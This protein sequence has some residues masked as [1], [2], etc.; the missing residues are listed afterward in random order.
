MFLKHRSNKKELLDEENI[1]KKDLYENLKELNTINYFLG[2]Y[3]VS[4]RGFRK[5]IKQNRTVKTIL[6]IGFGGGDS[7]KQFI[8]YSKKNKQEFFIYGVDMKRDCCSYADQNLKGYENFELICDDYR[9]IKPELLKKIDLVHASLFLHHLT[10]TQI[11]ELFQFCKEHNCILLI[12]DLHR[13]WL[14]YLSIK[15]LTK[16]FSKSYLVKNDAPLSVKRG[17]KKNELINLLNKAG[18]TSYSVSWSWA[19]RYMLIGYK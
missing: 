18:Y 17:F 19:F 5:L 13:H 4:L 10:D 9:N 1:P 11:I 14:A 16:L 12:N 15:T 8:K 6:D 3:N 7:I 2:G